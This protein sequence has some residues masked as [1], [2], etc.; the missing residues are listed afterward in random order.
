MVG[1]GVNDVVALGQADVGIA[2]GTV[3]INVQPFMLIC[4][5]GSGANIITDVADMVLLVDDLRVL[6]IALDVC[7]TISRR[8][9]INLGWA[10]VYN[11]LI[12]PIAA[13]VLY[14][15]AMIAIPPAFAGLSE[16]LSTLPIFGVS[17]HLN[18]YTPPTL[19]EEV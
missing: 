15:P 13:G 17:L 18:R 5:G 10:F 16:L 11:T 19:I 7:L 3:I 4:N 9:K 14:Y 6:I 1:D 2:M 8:I 12:I